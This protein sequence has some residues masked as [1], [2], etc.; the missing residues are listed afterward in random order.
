MIVLAD[1]HTTFMH[2]AHCDPVQVS[3]SAA[4]I[5]DNFSLKEALDDGFFSDLTVKS[6]D[7][8]QFPV[9]RLVLASSSPKLSYRDWEILLSGFKAPLVRVILE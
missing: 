3:N 2:N 1:M 6:C 5:M 8:V 4:V 7:S 9:H